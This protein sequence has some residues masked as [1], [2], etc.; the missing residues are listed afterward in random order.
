M[1]NQGNR[2]DLATTRLSQGATAADTT[3]SAEALGTMPSGGFY[4]TI[5]PE[6]ELPTNK[7]SEI[8][9][10]G[11]QGT[12]AADYK[13]GGDTS[14]TGTPTPSA[15]IPVNTVTGRQSVDI[16]STEYE[17]NLG[18]NLF[19]QSSIVQGDITADSK[20]IRCINSRNVWL[21]SGTY[22]FSW[23]A[24]SPF[25]FSVQTN[26]V[27]PIPLSSYPPYTY[28]SDWQSGV[29]NLTFTT[30]GG[31]L[32]VHF[33]KENSANIS[34][35]ELAQ[36]NI[37]L[38][39]GST[40]TPYA[41]YIQAF[42][43]NLF[44]GV[45]ELGGYENGAKDTR[46]D[47]YRCSNKITVQ[48]NTTYTFSIDGVAQK[49]VLQSYNQTGAYINE[50]D[51][52]TGTFTTAENC[53]YITFRCFIADFTSNYA[54]LKVQLEQGSTATTYEPNISGQLE[55]C[56]IGDYQDYIY[57]NSGKWYYH[58]AIA[59]LLAN[60]NEAWETGGALGRMNL[61]NTGSV[62]GS[63]TAQPLIS[64]KYKTEFATANGNCY[65]SSTTGLL[66][67]VDT[68]NAVSGGATSVSAW[69]TYLAS[70]PTK[71]Y[72]ALAAPLDI[73]ITNTD[74]VVQLEALLGNLSTTS[75][76][77]SPY[78]PALP[79][80]VMAAGY[81]WSDITRGIAPTTAKEWPAGAIVTNGIYTANTPQYTPAGVLDKSSCVNT[82]NITPGAVTGVT[83]S[84]STQGSAGIALGTIGT[85]NLRDQ[86]VT[87]SKIDWATVNGVDIRGL[88][89]AMV[90]FESQ[91]FA[92]GWEPT[93]ADSV[94]NYDYVSIEYGYGGAKNGGN[95]DMLLLP[96]VNGR[97]Y[98]L[99]QVAQFNT[100]T[101]F[102]SN[103][104]V[105]IINNKLTYH[106]SAA[107][108]FTNTGMSGFG[109]G[110]E[111]IVYRVI[112]WKNATTTGVV[113]KT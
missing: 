48:P 54:S 24:P 13:L 111:V 26:I 97:V 49:Y 34:V 86:S 85:P 72:Y 95:I 1:Q 36:Y 104:R 108:A 32:S 103:A 74:L 25:R 42:G 18:K 8:I 76:F 20:S 51:T 44:S 57:K 62:T 80:D 55:L 68:T 65:L 89:P 46:T 47:R 45:L 113:K 69:K 78:L 6:G 28:Q 112:G 109:T 39:K 91:D 61:P 92:G 102:I 11:S 50:S 73:E 41:P 58:M 93:L 56:K 60:G 12:T 14:Q 101:L 37:Q 19:D 10:V 98:S 27:G 31:W 100:A 99:G 105:T 9:Y 110:N 63:S 88:Y 79:F 30:T 29:S 2:L 53:Y 67:V 75:T 87:S 66:S 84:A 3:M 5:M 7:N 96:M 83:N 33:S 71:F 35:S 106:D 82:G 77:T 43:K 59:K 4:A 81:S 17:I 16:N 38:E 40:A 70:N 64:N 15:P 107:V 23:N 21:P 22:T 94:T 52:Q 90:L